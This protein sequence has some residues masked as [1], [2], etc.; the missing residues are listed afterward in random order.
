MNSK[1]EGNDA[2]DDY[3]Q[4]DTVTED[5]GKEESDDFHEDCID[6]EEDFELDMC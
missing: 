4:G 3:F 5:M 2:D 6:A 1:E